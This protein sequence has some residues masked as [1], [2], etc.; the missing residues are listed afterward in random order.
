M[1]QNENR[2]G[3]LNADAPGDEG[4]EQKQTPGVDDNNPEEVEELTD[5]GKAPANGAGVP[6]MAQ[7]KQ[8]VQDVP[9]PR[10]DSFSRARLEQLQ[11]DTGAVNSTLS[12]METMLSEQLEKMYASS[13]RR[14]YLSSA[15]M[16]F[17]SA[18][19]SWTWL[20]LNTAFRPEN[21]AHATANIVVDAI[22][23]ATDHLHI[24]LIDGAPDIA[25]TFSEHL[26]ESIPEYRDL[27]AQEF[28]VTVQE[29]SNALAAKAVETALTIPPPEAGEP[30]ISTIIRIDAALEQMYNTPP[31]A[32]AVSMNED[33]VQMMSGMTLTNNLLEKL[34]R[35]A[36]SVTPE[37][38]LIGWLHIVSLVAD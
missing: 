36:G 12:E 18:L 16:I 8:Q 34:D 9:P 17:I 20:N 7:V 26:I 31:T 38:L 10:E 6:E 1:A 5:P 14:L 11:R 13:R 28:L 4:I 24:L 2:E 30:T 32:G 25:E 23:N 33:L 22:P 3:E 37:E 27:L 19:L 35:D 21:L 15:M 29:V